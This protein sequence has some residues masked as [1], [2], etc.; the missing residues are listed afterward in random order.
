MSSICLT[1]IAVAA[2]AGCAPP[3]NVQPT[4]L[5]SGAE[6][7]P[8]IQTLTADG[9]TPYAWT[10]ASGQL[11]PGLALD[12]STGRLAGTPT[13][14]GTFEFAVTVNDASFPSRVGDKVYTITIIDRLTLDAALDPAR[15]GQ[16]Y[17]DALTAGGG[18]PPYTFAIVG[19]PA[20][21]SMDPATGVISGTPLTPASALRID[22]T[23]AD[24]GS[25]R[26]TA[27][28]TTYLVVKPLSVT[29]TTTALP[30]GRVN[31]SYSTQMAA[32]RGFTPYR[33]AVIAGVLP[34]GVNLNRTTGVISGTPRVAQT[35]SF[36]ME[37]TDSDSPATTDARL[38][39]IEIQP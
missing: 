18:V 19:L 31:Q 38:L 21:L 4:D 6:G 1:C 11:P 22:A 37:V 36:T 2:V 27:A 30:G 13:T 29:I 32:D 17:N 9:Q 12:R 23:V 7:Q 15:V 16:A 14:H 10:V 35:A 8:Y 33:W 20:G 39:T 5:P 28:Q 3:L 34:D 25:P 24:S 26:Q